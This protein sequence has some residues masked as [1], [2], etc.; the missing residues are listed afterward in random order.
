MIPEMRQDIWTQK[1]IHAL[2]GILALAGLVGAAWAGYTW[3][4]RSKEQGAYRDLAQSIDGYLKMRYGASEMGKWADVEKG[5]EAGA[6]RNASSKLLPF[7]L[8]YQ[9]DALI[10]QGK[11][12]EAIGLMDR[13]VSLLSPANPLY[14]LYAIKRALLKI[15]FSDAQTQQQGRKE[16]D[17]L[18]QDTTNPMQD[19]ARYYSG[20]DAL[21]QGDTAK[22]QNLFG[23]I[24]AHVPSQ[25]G[26]E[27]ADSLWYQMAQ[28]KLREL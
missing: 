27:E 23:Q 10:E 6:G 14:F 2:A 9:A 17:A 5:F 13:S 3:Y 26:T 8:A 20:V 7:F 28:E 15:D 12:K 1:R 25:S 4:K 19:M 24:R 18:M 16:L 11:L 22:A 21:S